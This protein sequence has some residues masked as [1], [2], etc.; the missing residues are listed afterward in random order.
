MRPIG[1][2]TGALAYSDFR[3]GISMIRASRVLAVELSALRQ[4]ELVPLLDALDSLD[5]RQFSYISIHAPSEF[6]SSQERVIRDR[7]SQELWRN[8]PIVIH[9]DTIRNFGLWRDFGPLLAVEN[10]DK[11]KPIGRSAQELDLIF[12]RLPDA[13]LCFDI[14]HARQIDPTMM[15]AYLIL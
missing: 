1:F 3:C 15:E 8:W 9:P 5:L 4:S 11:R 12:K 2:S 7:L 14:G 13:T 6:S 10:M